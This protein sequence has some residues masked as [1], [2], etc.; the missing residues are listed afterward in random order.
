MPGELLTGCCKQ[1]FLLVKHIACPDLMFS[2][3]FMF[4]WEEPTEPRLLSL[5]SKRSLEYVGHTIRNER[6]IK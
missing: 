3:K 1:W 6:Q 4:Y 5:M 2:I